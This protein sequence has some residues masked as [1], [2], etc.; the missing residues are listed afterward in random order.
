MEGQAVVEAFFG[1]EGEGVGGL[2]RALGVER[3]REVAAARLDLGG[4]FFARLDDLFRLREVTCLGFGFGTCLQPSA[5]ADFE[6]PL[7]PPLFWPIRIAPTMTAATTAKPARMI[8]RRSGLSGV[9]SIGATLEDRRRGGPGM[10][11]PWAGPIRSSPWRRR[12]C[13]PASRI[14]SASSRS[15]AARATERS[16]SPASSPAPGCAASIP[17]GRRSRR[18]PRGSASTPR[19]GSPS[20]SAS[21]A[22]CPSPTPTSISSRR[23]AARPALAEAAR[24]LRPGGSLLLVHAERP[25]ADRLGLRRR[26]AERRLARHGFELLQEGGAGGGSFLVMRLRGRLPGTRSD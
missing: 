21:R 13:T 7:S 11:G 15:A 3:D 14:P 16:S 1:E 23:A 5:P 22:G 18:R 9:P 6:P 10:I 24:V 19:A 25:P 8:Q 20:R 17:P 2:R 12:C 4:D 26:L